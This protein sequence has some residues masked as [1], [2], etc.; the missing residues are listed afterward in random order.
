MLKRLV[1]PTPCP[2]QSGAAARELAEPG[3]HSDTDTSRPSLQAPLQPQ[4]GAAEE[5][6]G[7]GVKRAKGGRGAG[8]GAGALGG[9]RSL[10][11]GCVKQGA[12]TCW[13]KQGEA[14]FSTHRMTNIQVSISP[15][16]AIDKIH[17]NQE[18]ASRCHWKTCGKAQRLLIAHPSIHSWRRPETPTDSEAEPCN[19]NT[20]QMEEY[21]MAVSWSSNRTVNSCEDD[22]PECSSQA[23]PT[24]RG[25]SSRVCMHICVKPQRI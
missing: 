1:P 13:V 18:G 5:A 10:L 11:Q 9:Y 22:T 17:S 20:C 24:Q 4:G 6:L 15:V 12:L 21:R 2:P 8:G 3:R 23:C 25:Q 7:Q 14:V 19:P 16:G